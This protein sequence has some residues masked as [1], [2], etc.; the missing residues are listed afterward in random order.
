M[1]IGSGGV[2]RRTATGTLPKISSHTRSGGVAKGGAGGPGG[3][4]T[5]FQDNGGPIIPIA[6]VQLIY[7][8][9]AWGSS[10][11]PNPSSDQISAAMETVFAGSYMT[12]LIQYRQIG[13]AYL[14]GSTVYTNTDPPSP[15]SND[16]VSSFI[17]A[18]IQDGTIPNIGVADQA[19]YMVVMP[20]GVSSG[21]SFIGEH[22][23]Y[24]DGSGNNVHYGWITNPGSL[25]SVTSIL[26]HEL[27][28]SCSDPEG[29]AILGTPGT[30]SQG[31]WCEIG[32]V[33]YSDVV[34]DGVNVQKYWSQQDQQCI[35]P[36]WGAENFPQAGVQW[37]GTVPA[38]STATWFTYNWPEY[39]FVLWEAV[40]T[41]QTPGS[42]SITS[43]TKI[44][45]ASG[46]YITYWIDVTNLTGQ[47][48]Q[49]EG[50]Y[51]VLD[52]SA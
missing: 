30:C 48:V 25:D 38:N 49:F 14:W 29:S 11:P 6:K 15:F 7:W 1:A 36:V 44:E 41:T 9:A 3:G 35:G 37:T 40:P 18:R 28:E 13:R 50:R 8:G 2:I 47:D 46:A 52:R 33:C 32:D 27:V 39:Y 16:D 31:G 34:I 5:G 22:T 51:I 42:P 17:Q 23:Y 43:K 19:L 24:T 10:P 45:R 12:G 26:T 20:V 21:G 4:S